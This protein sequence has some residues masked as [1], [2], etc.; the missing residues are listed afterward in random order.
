MEVGVK[1][2]KE[3]IVSEE[4][5]AKMIGSGL[6]PVFGTPRMIAL[7]EETAA[8][9]VEEYLE[10][11]QG[12]VGTKLEIEHSSATPIGMKVTCESELIEIDRKR[13]VFRVKAF[14]EVGPIGQ[15]IHER[16]IID[17]EKFLNK[18]N[19]KLVK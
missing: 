19:N 16:F 2:K 14:D 18:C 13:L 17:N 6:L 9:S 4:M 8:S 11:G 5:T 15:G 3:L 7:M 12:T 1:N 10:K